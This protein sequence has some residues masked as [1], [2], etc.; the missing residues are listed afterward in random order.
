M[1]FNERR[2]YKHIHSRIAVH[3]KKGHKKNLLSNK[4]KI[5]LAMDISKGGIF[6]LVSERLKIGDELELELLTPEKKEIPKVNICGIVR[7]ARPKSD[8]EFLEFHVEEF[9]YFCGVE[10]IKS[11]EIPNIEKMIHHLDFDEKKSN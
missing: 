11:K 2:K 1:V 9:D 4:K 8:D 3:Y 7:W 5:G 10:F 6:L